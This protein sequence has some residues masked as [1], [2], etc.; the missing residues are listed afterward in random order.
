MIPS[1]KTIKEQLNL[2]DQVANVVRGLMD[3]SLDPYIF[4]CVRK[5][6]QSAHN[7]HRKVDLVMEALD[8]VL[9]GHGVE[10]IRGEYVDSYHGDIQAVYV[11]MGESYQCTVI[12]DCRDSCFRVT[13]WGDFVERNPKR[14]TEN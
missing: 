12:Y 2:S 10:A 5:M 6:Q 11:N 8:E 14:F 7:P 4:K 1:K 3:F 9:E 13:S